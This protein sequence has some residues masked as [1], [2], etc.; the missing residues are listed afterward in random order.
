MINPYHL[1]YFVDAAKTGS[2]SEAAK[3]NRVSQ[4]AVSQAIRSLERSIGF[5][6]TTHQKKV[7]NLTD[8]GKAVLTQSE[9]VFRSLDQ[10]TEALQDIGTGYSG[11]L[12]IGCTNTVAL[13][14]MPAILSELGHLHPKLTTKVRIG[15]SE[16]IRDWLLRKDVDIGVFVDDGL[17]TRDFNKTALRSGH[18]LLFRGIKNH[19]AS[20]GLVV[21]RAD[22][23]E[24]QNILNQLSRDGHSTKIR[25]EITSWEAI[26]GYVLHAGGYG[27]CPDYVIEVELKAK[28]LSIAEFPIKAPRYKLIAVSRANQPLGKNGRLFLDTLTHSFQR[29]RNA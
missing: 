26:K 17:L 9:G 15:N 8:E 5:Q 20:D 29:G 1:R 24:V 4:S 23:K 12:T 28:K 25:C 19:Q 14:I 16:V 13:G 7:L 2:L 10:L 3:K 18:Y 21:T 6:L 27:I 22:R 11:T